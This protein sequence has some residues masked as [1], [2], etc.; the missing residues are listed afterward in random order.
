MNIPQ[1]QIKIANTLGQGV[2]TNKFTRVFEFFIEI[3]VLLNVLAVVLE[4]FD[5]LFRKYAFY[6]SAFEIFTVSVFSVEYLLR[7]WV[8]PIKYPLKSKAYAYKKYFFSITSYI[9]LIAI[10]PFFFSFLHIDLRHLRIFRLARLL[11]VF[12][13]SKYSAQLIQIGKIIREKK[14]EL[15][16]TLLLFFSVLVIACS[17]MFYIEKDA[18]PEAFP[19]ILYTFW[20]GIITLTTTGYGDVYPIT[21]LGKVLG[22]IVAMMG[23]LIVAIPTAIISSSFVQKMNEAKYKKRMMELR[24]KL[25]ASFYKKYIPE[26]ACKVRRGQISLEAVKV[27]LE[28]TEQDIYSIAEGKNEFRLRIKKMH[29]HGAHFDKVFLEYREINT[30]YGTFTERKSPLVL[31]SPESLNRQGIG[32]F[33]YCLS[34][35]LK[36]SYISNEFYGDEAETLEESFGDKGLEQENAFNFRH[37]KAYFEKTTDPVPDDFYLWVKHLNKLK[38]EASLY[39]VF[40]S[41]ENDSDRFVHLNYYKKII[42]GKA[43]EFTV[44]DPTKVEKFIATIEANVEYKFGSHLKVTTNKNLKKIS[45]NNIIEYINETMGCD[46]ILIEINKNYLMNEKLFKLVALLADSIKEEL[47]GIE[48]VERE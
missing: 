40:N 32:Y 20:W 41:I 18:Q 11:R 15:A 21:G 46:V 7:L 3:L 42:V 17:L 26:L 38:G 31:V 25:K 2:S 24:E 8:A 45:G 19:N 37:N 44:K 29:S 28:L 22:S 30:D 39:L 43:E 10:L 33:V 6:F 27:S 36:C 4:S 12:K 35:K 1:L 47:I 34:E 5:L 16:A 13:L 48:N 23:V 14:Q 9:D